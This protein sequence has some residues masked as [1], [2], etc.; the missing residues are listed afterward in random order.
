M[1]IWG[2]AVAIVSLA[3]LGLG[4][5]GLWMWWMRRQERAAGLILLGANLLF[6]VVVLSLMRAGGP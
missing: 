2:A 3:I 1:K 6:S 5:T 4:A